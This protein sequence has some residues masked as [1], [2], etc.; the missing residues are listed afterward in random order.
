MNDP[1][2]LMASFLPGETR[3]L[4]RQGIQMHCLQYWADA[5]AP[6]VGEGKQL[7]VL[8]DPRDISFVY[9]RSPFG[10]LVKAPVTTPD[11]F[12]I[13]LA[14]WEAR[15]N[16]ERALC[17]RPD[18]I[19]IADA[20]QKRGDQLVSQA[21]AQRRVRRRLATQAAG[22]PRRAPPTAP[23]TV[24]VEPVDATSA[25]P[26]LPSVPTLFEIEEYDDVA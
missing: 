10:K 9:V 25:W 19:A 21:K 12:P 24:Q 2:E 8:Y 6:W 16:A 4:T 26:A 17:K 20:S 14:E 1:S 13:S 5:L 22:D 7:Q 15:R 11:V 3:R 23:P 18:L